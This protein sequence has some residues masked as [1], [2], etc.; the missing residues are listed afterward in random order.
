MNGR[1]RDCV[2]H[3]A[4]IGLGVKLRLVAPD[5]GQRRFEGLSILGAER[6]DGPVLL[7]LERA[8]FPLPLDDQLEAQR[9]GPVRPR[10]RS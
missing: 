7:R 5:F 2:Y 4:G 1:G 3:G 9:S 8:D 10:D 6:L